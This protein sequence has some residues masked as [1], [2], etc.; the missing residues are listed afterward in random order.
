MASAMAPETWARRPVRR[1]SRACRAIHGAPRRCLK[2]PTETRW[3][4]PDPSLPSFTSSLS[5]LLHARAEAAM[6][7]PLAVA[8][9]VA[10]GHPTHRLA[11]VWKDAPPSPFFVNKRPRIR[12]RELST[13]LAAFVR[14]SF[15]FTAADRHVARFGPLV[16][17]F[18]INSSELPALVFTV[19]SRVS[20]PL[21]YPELRIRCCL[22][23]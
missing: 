18:P 21:C 20:P 2:A 23:V 17:L 3:T 5:S 1:S 19:S 16:G 11:F 10:T 14:S 4:W 15:R 6:P 13:R 9:S 22:L 8:I 12:A 7:S